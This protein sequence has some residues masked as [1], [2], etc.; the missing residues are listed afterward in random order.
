MNYV[1]FK[2]LKTQLVIKGG[3][4]MSVCYLLSNK[5]VAVSR[6]QGQTMTLGRRSLQF[7]E[8]GLYVRY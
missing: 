8:V 3:K 6:T 2:N 7:G 5:G 1:H 4:L